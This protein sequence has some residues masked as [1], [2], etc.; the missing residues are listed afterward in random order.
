MLGT[1]PTQ[2][3]SIF[4]NMHIFIDESGRFISNDGFSAVCALSIPDKST[5]PLRREILRI[6]KHWPREEGELKGGLLAVDHLIALTQVL[7]HH[8]AVLDCCAIDVSLET[9]ALV[10]RHKATQCENI[11]KHLTSEHAAGVVAAVWQLRRVLEKMPSQLYLQCVLMFE[12]VWTAIQ[13]TTLF[14][15]QRKPREL[16]S[17]RWIVDAKDPMRITTQEKWWHDTI[18]PLGE[19][20]ARRKPFIRVS[21][22]SF[23]YRFFQ[24]S[25]GMTKEMWCPDQPRQKVNGIDIKKLII[26][27]IT[28][29]DSKSDILIQAVDVLTRFTRRALTGAVHSDDALAALGRLQIYHKRKEVLQSVYLLTLGPEQRA[30]SGLAARLKKMTAAS[31]V[32]IKREKTMSKRAS[33]A[34]SKTSRSR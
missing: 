31:R 1:F 34:K 8:D 5:G 9:A 24:R 23:D 15:A 27:Q 21:D 13:L 18:G 32:M 10:Q 7:Y 2:R 6:S 12:A 26:D 14:F 3:R 17:F 30:R 4:Y 33:R 25:F 19:S 28:F 11:T 22:P 20:R 29:V 16:A